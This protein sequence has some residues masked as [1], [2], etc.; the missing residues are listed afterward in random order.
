MNGRP[1]PAA[2][3]VQVTAPPSLWRDRLLTALAFLCA[4]AALWPQ[5]ATSDLTPALRPPHVVGL[6]A[7]AYVA[8]AWLSRGAKRRFAG[9]HAILDI[10]LC[11][12]LG[13]TAL[14]IAFPAPLTRLINLF[15]WPVMCLTCAGVADALW[16]KRA[17]LVAA[18]VALVLVTVHAVWRPPSG[19]VIRES[20]GNGISWH[21]SFSHPDQRIVKRVPRPDDWNDPAMA[22][23]VRIDLARPYRGPAGFE[24]RVNDQFV[25][26]PT[27]QAPPQCG[28]VDENQWELPVPA[29]VMGQSSVVTIDLRPTAIDPDLAIAGHGDP[30]SERLGPES[31]WLFDGARWT[32][33]HLS[34]TQSASLGTYRVWLLRFLGSAEYRT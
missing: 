30:F 12:L 13:S 15:W 20:L 26:A 31:T 27:G 11:L 29:K 34:G 5:I 16:G 18:Q 3:H 14:L 24:V 22:T 17:A 6:A 8:S 1:A 7:A 19:R 32:R 33:D 23:Y 2:A 28:C 10:G 4:A 9:L 25:G 21:F